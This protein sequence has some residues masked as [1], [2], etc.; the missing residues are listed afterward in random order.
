MMTHFTKLITQ[1]RGRS[2][3]R[4]TALF[5]GSNVRLAEVMPR[6]CP[7]PSEKTPTTKQ[8][9]MKRSSYLLNGWLYDRTDKTNMKL[10][11]T[12]SYANRG[13]P[14]PVVILMASL[15]SALLFCAS[16]GADDRQ[17]LPGHVPPAVAK[18]NL[19]PIGRLPAANRLRLA[20]GLP[21]R[22]ANDLEGLLVVNPVTGK[23]EQPEVSRNFTFAE[24]VVRVQVRE[25]H[26]GDFLGPPTRWIAGFFSFMLAVLS[27]TG[28]LI[29]WNR[30]YR[31]QC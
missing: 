23:V 14:R 24:R 2:S 17:V 21:L 1:S 13:A 28:P 31:M 15:A 8:H 22:G 26:T 18:L 9:S 25:I 27:V 12:N 30:R 10:N 7:G 4:P 20:I 19:Q 3:A 16:A 11:P 6:A 5:E 29:W